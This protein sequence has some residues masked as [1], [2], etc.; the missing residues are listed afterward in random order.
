[1]TENQSRPSRLCQ[2]FTSAQVASAFQVSKR[3]L[4]RWVRDRLIRPRY[5][6]RGGACYELVFLESEVNRFMDEYLPNPED[7]DWKHEPRSRKQ[8]VE[9]IRRIR[10]LHRIYVGRAVATKMARQ[11]ARAEGIDETELEQNKDN[12]ETNNQEPATLDRGS[13]RRWDM[14]PQ[15]PSDRGLTDDEWGDDF[16]GKE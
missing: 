5:R 2:F 4:Y 13:A 16:E 10:N 15:P 9:A 6:L 3:Q 14:Q 12:P 8:R 1:M 7:L 11:L